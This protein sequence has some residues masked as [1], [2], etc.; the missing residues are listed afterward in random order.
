MLVA[1]LYLEFWV[2][3]GAVLIFGGFFLYFLPS[4][5]SGWRGV[6]RTGG[7]VVL[8]ILLGWTVIGWIGAL[9]W[10]CTAETQRDARLREAAFRQMAQSTPAPPRIHP[11]W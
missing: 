8:N 9:I 7:I 6:N 3:A 1:L 5:A 10:A 2:M 4:I 11:E